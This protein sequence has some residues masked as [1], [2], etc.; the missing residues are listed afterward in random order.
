MTG[1]DS[2]LSDQAAT[3][4][5]TRETRN[6]SRPM[7]AR[8]RLWGLY[9]YV[10]DRLSRSIDASQRQGPVVRTGSWGVCLTAQHPFHTS[11]DSGAVEDGR[12]M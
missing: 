2:S 4:L 8:M 3:N 10:R 6:A 1:S 11:L 5:L 7:R 12:V 9:E